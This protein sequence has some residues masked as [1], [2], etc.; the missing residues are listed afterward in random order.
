MKED[1][2]HILV[3]IRPIWANVKSQTFF[4]TGGTGFF[5]KW[6]LLSFHHIN[7]CLNLNNKLLVLSR[8]PQ[9]F[10]NKYP[11]FK[12]L[13]NIEFVAGDVRNFEFPENSIDYIIHAA[14]EASVALNLD[15]P[16]LMYNTIVDGTK[17][18]LE[19]AKE[20]KVNAV[21][22]T[23]SGA[24]YGIQPS[25][26]THISEDFNGCPAVYAANAAYGE[27][28][29]VSEML[30]A[31]FERKFGIKSKIARCYAFI[32][33]YLPLDGAF[34]AGNFINDVLQNK[35]I[36]INSD[37]TAYRSYLYVT[38][39]M[40]WLWTILFNGESSR[41]YNVGSEEDL[42]IGQLAKLVS[43]YNTKCG[44]K[45][46]IEN[47]VNLNPHRYV[48]ST[49]RAQSELGL[50]AL[51]PLRTAVERTIAFYKTN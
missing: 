39:L 48:P 28:K 4:L 19:L 42:S 51:I 9:A 1:L 40:I 31:M 22:H 13:N 44:V 8:N 45:L 15:E 41:A 33:P 38:D 2:D 30:A 50:S 26:I 14:T 37:G 32:G 27:G 47:P 34:A 16:L 12:N 3:N 5:G 24:V 11:Q 29:R 17:R 23:S 7:T 21:L 46:A 20:K 10:L 18:V 36:F 43:S 6:F 25:E 35:D 49:Q